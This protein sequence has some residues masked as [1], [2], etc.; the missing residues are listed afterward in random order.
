M[1]EMKDPKK[2]VSR[3]EVTHDAS[4]MTRVQNPTQRFGEIIGRIDDPRKMLHDDVPVGFPIL[5]GEELNV[6]VAGT[7]GG[8]FGIDKLDSGCIVFAKDSG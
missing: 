7:F 6:S 1:D 2:K 8:L 5:N 4:S 3:R